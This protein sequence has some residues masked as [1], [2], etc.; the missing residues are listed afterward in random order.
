MPVFP[1]AAWAEALREALNA[2][3]IYAEAAAAWE[4]DFLLVMTPEPEHPGGLGVHLDLFRGQ[5]RSA[6]FVEPPTAVTSEFTVEGSRATWERL[7]R[8][9]IEPI[10]AIMGGTL[11]LKGNMMKAMRFT[12]AAQEMLRTAASVPRDP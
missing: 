2:N 11:R 8:G 5:C 10:P 3:P 4:G 6:R 12:R 1:S 9:E 7:F